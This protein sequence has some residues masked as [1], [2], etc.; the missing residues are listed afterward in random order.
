MVFATHK[1]WKEHVTNP[2]TGLQKQLDL[3]KQAK[4]DADAT[5]HAAE[6]R[7]ANEKASRRTRRI[8]VLTAR[9]QRLETDLSAKQTELDRFRPT[10]PPPPPL[11]KPPRT[12]S[13]CWRTK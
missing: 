5:D 11:P 4:T 10:T 6:G 9:N 2:T 1:N 8:A 3:A 7:P 13:R 12:D